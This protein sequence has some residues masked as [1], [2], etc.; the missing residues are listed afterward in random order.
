MDQPT[1][2]GRELAAFRILLFNSACR[3]TGGRLAT[4]IAESFF[5]RMSEGL[6][7]RTSGVAECARC[8]V[9]WT[10]HFRGGLMLGSSIVIAFFGHSVIIT[11]WVLL[12][13]TEWV[14]T[15]GLIIPLFNQICNCLPTSFLSTRDNQRVL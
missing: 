12:I 13:I 10:L 11:K 14:H 4:R 1:I 9:R 2:I 7:E 8:A 5:E 3:A 6:T 15:T